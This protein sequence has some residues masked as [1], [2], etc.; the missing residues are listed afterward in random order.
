M[1][2]GKS[3]LDIKSVAKFHS[4]QYVLLGY[5]FLYSYSRKALSLPAREIYTQIRAARNIKDS[6]GKIIN[7]DDSAIEFGFSDSNGMSKPT[8]RKAISELAERGF[9]AIIEKGSFPRKKAVY[10][11]IDDWKEWER[12]SV[13]S[14]PWK[15]GGASKDKN[16]KIWD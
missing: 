5:E 2:G 11:I 9:I 3:G 15:R 10:A 1:A 6:R 8:Y 14:K 7:R 13:T 4:K 16:E 12:L